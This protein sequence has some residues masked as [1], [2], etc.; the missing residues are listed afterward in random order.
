MNVT[1]TS[2]AIIKE[3]E[4]YYELLWKNKR[5]IK[6]ASYFSTFPVSLQMEI[7]YDINFAHLQQSLLF[8]NQPE[9]FL[10]HVSLLMKNIILQRGEVLFHQD[11][12]K[13]HM[14]CISV[15]I[16]EVLSDEDEQSPIISF[17]KGTILGK[18]L[19]VSN[20]KNT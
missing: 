10:R 12:V 14:I 4:N 19:I 7:T 17:K 11:V 13:T 18:Q 3:V 15:G 20:Y 9:Y 2:K 8:K 16:L 1:K 6:E 5:G